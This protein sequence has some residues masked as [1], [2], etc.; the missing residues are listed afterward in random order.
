GAIAETSARSSVS[1]AGGDAVLRGIDAGF[2]IVTIRAAGHASAQLVIESDD[3]GATVERRVTLGSGAAI[4]GV[5]VGPVGP[6]AEASVDLE[7]AS[8]IHESVTTD[9]AGRWRIEGIGA[10]RHV[11]SASATRYLAAPDQIIET[12]GV[13]ATTGIVARVVAGAEITGIVV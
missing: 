11:V 9:A 1:D 2:E 8:G 4:E 3:P 7:A 5:V 10:G 13:H 6:L 12:D